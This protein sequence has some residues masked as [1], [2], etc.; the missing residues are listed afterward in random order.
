M[1]KYTVVD[2]YTGQLYPA[3]DIHDIE[4]AVDFILSGEELSDFEENELTA[5]YYE[6]SEWGASFSNNLG[7]EVVP[8]G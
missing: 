1:S 7:I 6:V 5:L 2:V 8:H 3:N 4:Q